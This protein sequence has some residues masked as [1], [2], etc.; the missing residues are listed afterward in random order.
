MSRPD[1]LHIRFLSPHTLPPAP[2][3]TPAVEVTG[4]RA[5]YISGQ[6]ALDAAGNL[7]GEGDFEAQARQA[8]ANVGHALAAAGMEFRH[9]VKLGLYV[10]DMNQRDT[11]RLVRNEFVDVTQPPASTLVQVSA[12]FRPDV[13][14]EVDAVAVAP[15]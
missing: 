13:L 12:F 6:V 7:V 5:L 14:F 11:L 15:A 8:F 2:G 3:Y 9:V 1:D 4:G 10:L